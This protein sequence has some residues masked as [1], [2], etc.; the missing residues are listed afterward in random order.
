MGFLDKAK[1]LVGDNADKASDAID[2]VA[3]I[4]DDKTGNK[5]TEQI[6]T[7]A[8]KAKDF[9]ENLDGDPNN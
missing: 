9:V 6:D 5:H 4:V 7:A 3:D 2:K 1:D 8:E